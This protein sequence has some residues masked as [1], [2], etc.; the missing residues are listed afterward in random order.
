MSIS[1]TSEHT[2]SIH[3]TTDGSTPTTESPRYQDPPLELNATTRLS[4]I[5]VDA[6]GVVKEQKVADYI[7]PPKPLSHPYL[8]VQERT[9]YY[10]SPPL[11][12]YSKDNGT[13]WLSC[14]GPSQTLETLEAGDHVWV[15]HQI[16]STDIHDLGGEVLLTNGYDLVAGQAYVVQFTNGGIIEQDAGFLDVDLSD[17][18]ATIVIPSIINRGTQDFSGVVTLNSMHQK[19]R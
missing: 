4:A 2:S 6:N 3:Y 14:E 10:V 8:D 5:A 9:I 7:I 17:G 15:R 11:Y 1:I 19:T 16:V 12:E 13:T 18:D